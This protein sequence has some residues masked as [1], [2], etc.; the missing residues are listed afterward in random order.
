MQSKQRSQDADDNLSQI[1]HVYPLILDSADLKYKGSF[2]TTIDKSTKAIKLHSIKTKPRRDPD[3]RNDAKYQ[4]WVKQLE[5]NPFLINS[6]MLLG[7]S[8]FEEGNYLRAITTFMYITKIYSTD[9]RIVS[10]AKLWIARAY[11]E[12]GWMYEAENVLRKMEQNNEIHHELLGMYSSIKAN[13]YVH[14]KNYESA[15]PYLEEAIRKEKGSQ[16]R[17]NKYLLAQLY[18]ATG[19][20]EK[21]IRLIRM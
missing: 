13:I 10:E 18:Q 4:A 16:K 8:E 5:F 2:T 21:P 15:I 11:S 19:D 17:R 3:K 1:L 12:M 14:N 7:R 20:S 6:W 9:K